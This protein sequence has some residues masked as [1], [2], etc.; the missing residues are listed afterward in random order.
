MPFSVN[1]DI[2][3]NRTASPFPNILGNLMI[4]D[5]LRG[6]E[7][8]RRISAK[9]FL[10][11]FSIEESV[12]LKIER[13]AQ[14]FIRQR[15]VGE[16]YFDS[17]G[18]ALQYSSWCTKWFL[19]NGR[20]KNVFDILFTHAWHAKKLITEKRQTGM[21]NKVWTQDVEETI[22]KSVM[23]ALSVK[24]AETNGLDAVRFYQKKRESSIAD[25]LYIT[26]RE[27]ITPKWRVPGVH[28]EDI[29]AYDDID[30]T[31]YPRTDKDQFF[32]AQANYLI[33][34]FGA[35]GG[36][37]DGTT[38]RACPAALFQRA[39]LQSLGELQELAK[40]AGLEGFDVME[41]FN[42]DYVG[43]GA[44]SF[45]VC[46]MPYFDLSAVHHKNIDDSLL[47]LDG[48]AM[49]SPHAEIT[50]L[51]SV[52]ENIERE[53]ESIYATG[54]P[55][56]GHVFAYAMN[57]FLRPLRTD[58]YRCLLFSGLTQLG[59]PVSFHEIENATDRELILRRPIFKIIRH[60]EKSPF[61][62]LGT[63]QK[64][65]HE[66]LKTIQEINDAV[67]QWKRS[68]MDQFYP[69]RSNASRDVMS[70][71]CLNS[72]LG[73]SK[74]RCVRSENVHVKRKPR[75]SASISKRESPQ[76]DLNQGKSAKKSKA[77]VS[78]LGDAT[79]DVAEEQ[80]YEL[81]A[82]HYVVG[83]VILGIVLLFTFR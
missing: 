44:Y 15:K 61:W 26:W 4:N 2:V 83:A 10:Y 5:Y 3:I 50:A 30:G 17:Q 31:A 45:V 36:N 82:E 55:D 28:S 71:A 68:I 1:L 65:P 74:E 42:S 57:S 70:E 62:Q 21:H 27:H 20:I 39:F 38:W 16:Y 60:N 32:D 7:H 11:L 73:P 66:T 81:K 18:A 69:Q 48:I 22:L 29:Q 35:V 12:E 23:F 19:G 63:T 6:L 78:P 34:W 53:Y 14:R 52:L 54:I 56:K 77:K 33:R 80:E 47:G 64:V 72:N 46:C 40:L 43:D 76:T 79:Y 25:A 67:V 24:D 37:T 9:E 8:D 51:S 75:Q 13:A 58:L 49:L 59:F 41:T